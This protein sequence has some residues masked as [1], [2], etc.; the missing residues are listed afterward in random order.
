M[1][2]SPNTQQTRPHTVVG[3]PPTSKANT[4]PNT[5]TKANMYLSPPVPRQT[6]SYRLVGYPWVTW[7]SDHSQR[8]HSPCLIHHKHPTHKLPDSNNGVSQVKI[9]RQRLSDV[10]I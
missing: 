6:P 1:Y 9:E 3:T 8:C 5:D 7:P 10:V 4:K 2:I